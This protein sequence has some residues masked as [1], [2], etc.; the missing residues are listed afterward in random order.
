LKVGGDDDFANIYLAAFAYWNGVTLSQAQIE[1][2]NTAKTTQSILDLSPTA[3][4]DDSD[5]FATDLTAGTADRSSIVGTT[6]S[7][8]DPS[9]WVYLGGGAAATSILVPP[10]RAN[11]GL[12]FY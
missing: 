6:D 3:A 8:D 4:Y 1:G 9:G 5:A 7:A 11:R 10:G 12:T 2:I